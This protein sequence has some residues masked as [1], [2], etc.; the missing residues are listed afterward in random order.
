MKAEKACMLSKFHPSVSAISL[1]RECKECATSNYCLLA[2]IGA[3]DSDAY[4]HT[5]GNKQ[6]N[7]WYWLGGSDTYVGQT[8]PQYWFNE[9]TKMKPSY[10]CQAMYLRD[11][12]QYG[13]WVGLPCYNAAP[14]TCEYRVAPPGTV[15]PPNAGETLAMAEMYKNAPAYI[16]G[17]SM[18][19]G[20]M[21]F[22]AP[23]YSKGAPLSFANKGQYR[24]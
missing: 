19:K 18:S 9:I 11:S 24:V 8:G 10:N 13:K 16:G 4:S 5:S 23:S 6:H 22:R 12:S 21:I 1:A 7:K 3:A 17:P 20:S 15:A 2:C 14:F